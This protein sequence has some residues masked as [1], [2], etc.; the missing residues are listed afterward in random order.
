[1]SETLNREN[2][3]ATTSAEFLTSSQAAKRL[4]LS[5]A[6]IQ[7]LVDNN[8]LQAWRTFGGHRRISLASILHYQNANNFLDVPRQSTDR[9]AKV[10]LV[11]ESPEMTDRL[12]KDITQ[13]HLPLQ[14]AFQESLTEALLE[15][16]NDKHD[17]LVI[18]MSGLRKQ[19][20]KVLEILQKFMR[21]RNTVAHTLILTQENDLLPSLPSGAPVSIQVLNKDLS[22]MWLSAYL[23]GFI[24]QRSL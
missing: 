16:L 5:M 4:G 19:Q 3:N 13:W 8:V 18:Q 21:A 22:P 23:S 20:E 6:T 1:M 7:K 12:K 14:A 9:H 10:M 15:L 17:L 11:I 2:D 24:A